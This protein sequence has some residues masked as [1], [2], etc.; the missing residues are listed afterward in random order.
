VTKQSSPPSFHISG[1]DLV[2]G[3]GQVYSLDAMKAG[4]G[5]LNERSL[6]ANQQPTEGAPQGMWEWDDRA[7]VL[8]LA[9]GPISVQQRKVFRVLMNN[10]NEPPDE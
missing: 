7:G 10:S 5:G 2:V 9:T 3:D 6:R 4:A 8:R 1:V